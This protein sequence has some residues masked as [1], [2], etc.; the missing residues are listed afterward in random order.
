MYTMS[1]IQIASESSEVYP[2]QMLLSQQS[3]FANCPRLQNDD[4]FCT[5]MM[6]LRI[7]SGLRLCTICA[8][9]WVLHAL[10][11]LLQNSNPQLASGYMLP[12]MTDCLAN[13][14]SAQSLSEAI[15]FKLFNLEMSSL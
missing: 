4:V 13:S 1:W 11:N 2:M 6:R 14:L 7:R 10:L 3:L 12:L 8:W 5:T 15:C 9:D